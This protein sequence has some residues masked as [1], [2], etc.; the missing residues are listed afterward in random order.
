MPGYGGFA[1]SRHGGNSVA[2]AKA[3][4]GQVGSLQRASIARAHP[5]RSEQ[6]LIDALPLGVALLRRNSNGLWIIAAANIAFDEIAG[7]P[8]RHSLGLA[9]AQLANLDPVGELA[10]R[11]DSFVQSGGAASM[12]FEWRG[13]G[14]PRDRHFAVRLNWLPD[15]SGDPFSRL[16]LSIRDRSFEV[17]QAQSLRAD[18]IRDPLTGLYNHTG[19]TEMI[20]RQGMS[21]AIAVLLVDL[22]RFS[23]IVDNFGH[24]AGDELLLAVARRILSVTGP[25]DTVSRLH[26]D[27]FG[28][29]TR[30]IDGPGDALHLAARCHDAMGRRIALS[31]REIEQNVA[32]GIA[33][34]DSDDLDGDDILRN[35]EFAAQRAKRLGLRTE[36]FRSGE[37][38]KARRRFSLEADLRHA[39]ETGALDVAYQP[40]LRFADNRVASVEALARWDHPTRGPIPPSDFIP[41]AEETG[42]IMPLGRL[43]LETACREIAALRAD[44][45]AADFEVAV[46]LSAIQIG[47]D[48]VDNVR[49]ALARSGLPGHALKLELTESA[50]IANPERA[51]RVL[52]EL[53]KLDARIAMDDFGTGYSSLSHLQRLPIDA[54]KIDRSFIAN[55]LD[56]GDSY[57]IVGAMLS[58]ARSLRME[59]VAEGIESAE[60]AEVLAAM[61]CTYGQGFY[62]ARPLSLKSL[63]NYLRSGSAIAPPPAI[64]HAM[65]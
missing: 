65:R 1:I 5:I 34:A 51:V 16:Q 28:I 31:D 25:D 26:S 18:A 23:R 9:V 58:L 41:L 17:Q 7:L 38:A 62:F 61:G 64:P 39:I 57:Q 49:A 56:Y 46:N 19:F 15:D 29:L 3:G 6:A 21:P 43:I 42:L 32:I 52:D 2:S 37:A 36:V 45:P 20:D 11:V 60:Q 33:F 40:L 47:D 30:L 4:S 13:P 24:T 55:M 8:N 12:D 14:R 27:T 59:S 22:Q 48:I 10:R 44:L 35:A 50:I 54:L 63:G 53:K